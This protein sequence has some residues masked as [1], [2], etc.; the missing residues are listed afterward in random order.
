MDRR[1]VTLDARIG[2]PQ[3]TALPQKGIRMKAFVLA[4]T[5]SILATAAYAQGRPDTRA[6]SC[7]QAA[8]LVEARGAVVLT[9]GPDLYDRFVRDQGF[10][11]RERAVEPAYEPTADKAQCFIGYRCVLVAPPGAAPMTPR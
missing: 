8:A 7:G 5:L 1:A 4:A 10:C 11:T 2:L 9:T 6:M 3:A